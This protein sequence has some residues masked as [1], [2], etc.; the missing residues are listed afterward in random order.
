M[1]GSESSYVQKGGR[2]KSFVH[3]A[4]PAPIFHALPGKND[5]DGLNPPRLPKSI[6]GLAILES[7]APAQSNPDPV[8]NSTRAAASVRVDP[9]SKESLHL[10]A[11]R[12]NPAT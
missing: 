4:F 10:H 3:G 12:K 9:V 11:G 6:S 2:S 5:P 8:R 1:T 7:A